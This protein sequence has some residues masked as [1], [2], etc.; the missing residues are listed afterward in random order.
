MGNYTKAPDF[1]VIKDT[2]E[3]EGYYFS[4]YGSCLGMVEQKLDT[5]DYAIQGLED[6]CCIE[7]K[8]CIE[9]LAI[10]LGKTKHAF[11]NEIERMKSFPHKFIILEFELS[12]LV[13]FPENSRIPEKNKAK[14]KI[15]GKYM[16]KCLMEFQLYDDVHVLFCGNKR[17][18]FLTVSSILKR[19]N[20]MYTV[21]RKK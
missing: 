17:N 20:E 6:K 9:E 13:N 15:T 7:R 14:L 1:Y 11:L 5:G 18:G 2:R 16:L 21:G 4:A 3:Q 8:G 19:I 12:D 10:N